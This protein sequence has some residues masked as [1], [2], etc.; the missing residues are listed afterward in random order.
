MDQEGFYPLLMSCLFNF[1]PVISTYQP[2]PF[3]Q[4]AH[5]G[6]DGWHRKVSLAVLAAPR[7]GNLQHG[8]AKCVAAGGGVY[9]M[10]WGVAT[11]PALEPP[12]CLGCV[13]EL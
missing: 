6:G 8:E 9:G 4:L 10:E 5:R 13:D 2:L 3:C 1:S 12:G 7:N 11:A